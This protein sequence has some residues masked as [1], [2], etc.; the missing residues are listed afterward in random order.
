[1]DDR[2]QKGLILKEAREAKGIALETVHEATKIP[3]DALKA[4][5]EG[6]RVRTMTD[7][8]YRA[9]VKLYTNYLGIEITK[10]LED[11]QPEEIPK[12]MAFHRGK[13]FWEDEKPTI[14]TPNVVRNIIKAVVIIFGIFIVIRVGGC[15][16]KRIPESNSKKTTR[17]KTVK[18]KSTPIVM[19]KPIV[20]K[21]KPGEKSSRIS[22]KKVNL[23]V[24][25]KERTWLRVS[26][27]GSEVFRSSLSKG[28]VESWD[29]KERIELSGKNLRGLE[30][31]LNGKA[32]RSLAD[33]VR[34]IHK[35]VITPNG[36]TVEE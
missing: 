11:Y 33:G 30:L 16:F 20:A 22:G 12:P 9:F 2:A 10:V 23:V 27:D 3:L 17:A 21:S 7:F 36:F 1:M 6:Y 28:A 24:R 19:S 13:N 34:G 25:A 35:I 15:I 31:E 5:E 26:T 32:I 4:I 29:A 14:F 18:K 8:Y